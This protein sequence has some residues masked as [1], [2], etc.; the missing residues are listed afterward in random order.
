MT[1]PPQVAGDVPLDIPKSFAQYPPEA[2][3]PGSIPLTLQTQLRWFSAT[4]IDLIPA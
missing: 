4:V 1:S 2:L 3:S